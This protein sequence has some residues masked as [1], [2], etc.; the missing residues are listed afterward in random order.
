[1]EDMTVSSLLMGKESVEY[2]LSFLL[3][4]RGYSR[5]CFMVWSFRVEQLVAL[6][7]SIISKK[8]AFLIIL[9]YV[10]TMQ[11]PPS[12]ITSWKCQT[13]KVN[14]LPFFH[15]LPSF[16]S[17]FTNPTPCFW[18]SLPVVSLAVCLLPLPQKTA[19]EKQPYFKK[20]KQNKKNAKN[21]K[22]TTTTKQSYKMS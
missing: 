20:T 6:S 16:L 4:R 21:S 15:F 14:L 2:F 3:S 22:T 12:L 8:W 18:E 10:S 5:N 17:H 19:P 9:N 13:L 11:L 1:M 7:A